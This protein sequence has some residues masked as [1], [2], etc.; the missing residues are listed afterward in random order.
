MV[1]SSCTY[2]THA[3]RHLPAAQISTATT[4]TVQ[5]PCTRR[6]AVRTPQSAE[7]PI[8]EAT[9]TG[10]RRSLRPAG[11]GE[12]RE[13][14]GSC[15]RRQHSAAQL[16]LSDHVRC[17]SATPISIYSMQLAIEAGWWLAHPRGWDSPIQIRVSRPV[18]TGQRT[19]AYLKDSA[20][21]C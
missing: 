4:T 20:A 18:R 21:G 3:G 7:P 9:T 19:V 15:M 8:V 13:F 6:R 11:R 17:A 16:A 10:R 14:F 2:T 12:C 5:S 1:R